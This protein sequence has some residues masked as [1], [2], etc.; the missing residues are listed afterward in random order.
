MAKEKRRILQTLLSWGFR[1]LFP[2]GLWC[3]MLTGPAFGA[4]PQVTLHVEQIL[5]HEDGCESGLLKTFSYTLDATTE[6]APMP[7]GCTSGSYS[8]TLTGSCSRELGPLTFTN[9]GL[10][11]YV[12]RQVGGE[13]QTRDGSED[14]AFYIQIHVKEDASVMMTIQESGG[15]KV[16]VIVFST[17]VL[18]AAEEG[19]D[20]VAPT[21]TEEPGEAGGAGTGDTFPLKTYWGLLLGAGSLCIMFFW[22]FWRRKK[23]NGEE[24]EKTGQ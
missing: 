20:T 7:E 1:L 3:F 14:Q 11:T 21:E 2:V 18:G 16:E 17:L 4:S 15:G 12:L 6:N 8:F 10:Y 19:T 13:V 24:E 22:L 5:L 9:P 23:E